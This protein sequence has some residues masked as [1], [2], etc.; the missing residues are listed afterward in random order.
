M[1]AI[2]APFCMKAGLDKD[3]ELF[4]PTPLAGIGALLSVSFIITAFIVSY[5]DAKRY[6]ELYKSYFVEKSLKKVFAEVNYDHS[7]GM[8]FED[9]KSTGMVKTGNRYYSNDYFT[10]KYH[11]VS[12]RQADVKI[13]QESSDSEGTHTETIF[14]GRWMIFDFP[15][16]FDHRLQIVQKRFP[17]YKK[18]EDNPITGTNLQKISTESITFDKKFKTYAEDGFE[19]YYLL[20]PDFIEKVE[21]LVSRQKGKTMFIF[22]DNKLHIAV[23]NRKDAFETPNP[24]KKIDEAKEIEK[25]TDEIKIITNFVDYL[26][27]NRKMFKSK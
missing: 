6:K 15:K 20:S 5:K 3:H 13:V 22:K 11:D 16:K 27:L 4:N 24:L 12:F 25:I 10:G 2:L 26:K 1:A 18:A 14:E 17:A 23:H 21:E 9:I 19:A 8:P 7:A